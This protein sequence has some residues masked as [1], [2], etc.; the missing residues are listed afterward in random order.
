[1]HLW[2]HSFSQCSLWSWLNPAWCPQGQWGD[3]QGDPAVGPP[4]SGCATIP[5]FCDQTV[6]LRLALHPMC[7]PAAGGRVAE[8]LWDGSHPTPEAP[9]AIRPW[10]SEQ[11]D[12]KW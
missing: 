10:K 9:R 11:M 7:A 4:C 6:G 2:L 12:G 5:Q 1:M 3:V 8:Q